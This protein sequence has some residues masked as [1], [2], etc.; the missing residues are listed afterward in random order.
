MSVKDTA[1]RVLDAFWDRNIPVNIDDI[2]QK[3]GVEVCYLPT[4]PG[5]EDISGR[6]DIVNG[7]P[8][9]TVRSTD[10]LQRQRFTLAHELGHFAL[11]H[12]GGFRDNSASFNIANYDQREV[13]ANAFAAEL[14]MPTV[15][16]NYAIDRLNIQSINELA[17]LF[18]VSVPAMTYRLKNLGILLN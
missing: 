16:I 18:N 7:T 3:M 9:C 4:L 13:D 12:G 6:F 15:A 10:V 2:A 1:Q 5:G 11:N 8:T 14:V 17:E